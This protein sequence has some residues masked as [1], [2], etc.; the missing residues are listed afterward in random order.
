MAKKLIFERS[1]QVGGGEQV[2]LRLFRASSGLLVERALG[3]QDGR[4][5]VQILLL[6]SEQDMPQLAEFQAADEHRSLLMVPYN[7]VLKNAR[8]EFAD[9]TWAREDS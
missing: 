2:R 1:V 4:M 3:Q 8:A 7:E 6:L 9:S 5:L